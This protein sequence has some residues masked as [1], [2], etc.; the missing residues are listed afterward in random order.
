[1][2]SSSD[3]VLRS[4]YKPA[5]IHLCYPSPRY[6]KPMFPKGQGGRIAV[7]ATL[8]AA[9]PHQFW[10]RKRAVAEAAQAAQ[11]TA[12]SAA[13]QAVAAANVASTLRAHAR[14]ARRVLITKE[15]L[16][17]KQ[18]ARKAGCLV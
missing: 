14:L 9:A 3:T 15:D 1:M 7:D 4:I 5:D 18:L 12:E 6:V 13:E 10:R 16:R 17:V 2:H 8:R 11:A